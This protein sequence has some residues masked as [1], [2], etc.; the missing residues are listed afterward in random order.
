MVFAVFRPFIYLLSVVALMIIMVTGGGAVLREENVEA[1][2]M[3]GKLVFL[4]R[5]IEELI[6]TEDRPL[7]NDHEKIKALYDERLPVYMA[8]ADAVANLTGW[9]EV[10]ADEI[11]RVAV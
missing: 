11:W 1:L 4:N 10:P 9:E 5:P 7:A 2:A 6:P 8:A 3:N